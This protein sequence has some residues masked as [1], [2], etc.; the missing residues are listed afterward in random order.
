MIDIRINNTNKIILFI[1]SIKY[2]VKFLWAGE[3]P[4]NTL[5]FKCG[6][7]NDYIGTA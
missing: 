7:S 2:L 5:L 4:F 1:N 6:G 3:F